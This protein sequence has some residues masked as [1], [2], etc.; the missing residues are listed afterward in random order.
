[1]IFQTLS[2]PVFRLEYCFHATQTSERI[3]KQNPLLQ[4]NQSLLQRLFDGAL[5]PVPNPKCRCSG[6]PLD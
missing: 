4:K 1:M 6:N 2:R 5:G 3:R